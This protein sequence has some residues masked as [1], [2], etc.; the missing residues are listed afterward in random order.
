MKKFLSFSLFLIL[1][2]AIVFMTAP[3]IGT[4]PP[5]LNN[6]DN[7]K[8]YALN[9]MSDLAIFTPATGGINGG[10]SLYILATATPDK[11]PLN[12]FYITQKARPDPGILQRAHYIMIDKTKSP[13][14]SSVIVSRPSH[15]LRT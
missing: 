10:P 8:I 5:D 1:A 3:V 15:P 12:E 6:T 11:V 2:L 13:W 9:Q 14:N 7:T 4:G